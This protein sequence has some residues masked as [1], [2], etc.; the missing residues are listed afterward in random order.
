MSGINSVNFFTP[1]CFDQLEKSW[2]ETFLE[3]ADGYFTISDERACVFAGQDVDGS[4]PTIMDNIEPTSFV[5]TALKV[6]SY[7]TLVLPL[8]VLVAKVALR[9]THSFH[10]VELDKKVSFDQLK[11][12]TDGE[13]EQVKG[14]SLNNRTR[15]LFQYQANDS[16]ENIASTV[17]PL[18]RADKNLYLN[19]NHPN[20]IS[21]SPASHDVVKAVEAREFCRANKLDL[22]VIPHSQQFDT[23][24]LLNKNITRLDTTTMIERLDLRYEISA[25]EELFSSLS[26]LDEAIKQLVTYI[27]KRGLK[28]FTETSAFILQQDPNFS[29]NRQIVLFNHELHNSADMDSTIQALF[30]TKSTPGLIGYLT[31]EKQIDLMIAEA[32]RHG[33]DHPLA[34]QAKQ[35]RLQ[36]LKDLQ[37]HYKVEG[38]LENPRKPIAI[39]DLSTLGLDLKQTFKAIERILTPEEKKTMSPEIQKIIQELSG[40]PFTLEEVIRDLIEMFNVSIRQS[41]DFYGTRGRREIDVDTLKGMTFSSMFKMAAFKVFELHQVPVLHLIF[42]ALKKNGHVYDY[43][44]TFNS[45]GYPQ[46]II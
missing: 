46:Y 44:M 1:I 25:Q 17:L 24:V 3:A 35:D 23:K 26:N 13:K 28:T 27:V 16:F 33:I 34:E 5:W 19:P 12:T 15:L 37:N 11:P 20:L 41:P 36:K 29:G 42:E 30:G 43:T 6:A 45:S 4:K 39:N 31:T 14:I 2:S 10:L 18:G 32:K 9:I 8:I 40:K 22:L 7:F 21:H 38:I